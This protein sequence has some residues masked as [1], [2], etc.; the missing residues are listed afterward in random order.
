MAHYHARPEFSA[1]WYEGATAP[2][3]SVLS[4]PAAPLL[5]VAL[6][7]PLSRKVAEVEYQE[8]CIVVTSFL[9]AAQHEV[10]GAQVFNWV[11]HDKGRSLVLRL[12][13]ASAVGVL[14][15]LDRGAALARCFRRCMEW[16]R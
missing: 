16:T 12:S 11:L 15:C 9:D 3:Q 13:P 14:A 6:R 2:S 5:K 8:A 1:V 7:C 10:L 4:A